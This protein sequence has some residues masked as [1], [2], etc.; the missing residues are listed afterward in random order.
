MSKEKPKKLRKHCALLELQ[1]RKLQLEQC[2]TEIKEKKAT[3]PMGF[4][5]EIK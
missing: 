5:K 2:I 4:H 1:L 3:T